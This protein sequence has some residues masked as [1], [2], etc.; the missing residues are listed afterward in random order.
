MVTRD[1]AEQSRNIKSPGIRRKINGTMVGTKDFYEIYPFVPHFMTLDRHKLHYLDLGKGSPVVMVHGNP[2]WSFYFRRLA[3]DLSVN[4]RVIVPDHMG[5]GLSDKPS[6][7][8]Y[9]YTLASRVR[10]LDRLIQ[11]LDLGKKI[12][13]VV[14]DWG[15]MIGCAWALRHLDRIDRIIITNTSGFHL[16]GAKRFPLRLWLIKYLPWF[17]IPGIQG[18]NLF[19]R[20]ALYMAPKQSL[21]TTVRQGLTAPY[22]SWKNRIATLKFVQDIPLSPRDKSYELVNWVDTHLEGL[23]TVPMMI[24]WG[25]HDFVFDLSFLDEW[26]KRFPHAQTHIFEDAG[27]YLFEDKP[28]ETSNLIKKFIEEY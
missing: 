7:R 22:N 14:H 3:R 16:P 17:A 24:L 18:L 9:D 27:H 19:A 21:S 4:H 12:T 20:A 5:C 23:K 28:D 13:L 15:G 6:T 11:S 1:P 26:N 8:D 25:R 10:D 2:T